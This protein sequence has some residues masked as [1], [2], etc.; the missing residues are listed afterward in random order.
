MTTLPIDF[1]CSSECSALLHVKPEGAGDE[2]VNSQ[3]SCFGWRAC[4][5]TCTD[6]AAKTGIE[7]NSSHLPAPST[8]Q[9]FS[10]SSP[11]CSLLQAPWNSTRAV[12]LPEAHSGALSQLHEKAGREFSAAVQ[13]DSP[14]SEPVRL[15]KPSKIT[16][17]SSLLHNFWT[18]QTWWLHLGS[19]SSV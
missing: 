10:F 7:E 8:G 14:I 4:S 15:E 3:K 6:P 19:L 9:P 11:L 18:V 1:I 2:T 16:N 12:N 17:P 5:A 13:G